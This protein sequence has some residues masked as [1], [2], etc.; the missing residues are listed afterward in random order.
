MLTYRKIAS[1]N[2]ILVAYRVIRVLHPLLPTNSKRADPRTG[3]KTALWQC[4]PPLLFKNI[5]LILK[6][7][8]DIAE[9]VDKVAAREV[10]HTENTKCTV[11]RN[12]ASLTSS[13]VG[14]T[15]PP[16]QQD[17]CNLNL[18]LFTRGLNSQK[19]SG[20]PQT[21]QNASKI[22]PLLVTTCLFTH[23]L[24]VFVVPRFF[25]S[26]TT[27]RIRFFAPI[28]SESCI[29]SLHVE[30]HKSQGKYY[31]SGIYL[32]SA[33]SAPAHATTLTRPRCTSSPR[34]GTAIRPLRRGRCS[35]APFVYAAVS[36]NR[37]VVVVVRSRGSSRCYA[38]APGAP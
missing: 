2:T 3:K 10:R 21:A 26:R 22:R 16:V 14:H 34:D 4:A 11:K 17:C 28:S 6:D 35:V 29:D 18:P 24:C 25:Y 38:S 19:K 7:V 32:H 27:G 30:T 1:L 5:C 12:L 33:A 31:R 23:V 9:Y 15:K 36:R 20:L 37:A 13:K 8:N